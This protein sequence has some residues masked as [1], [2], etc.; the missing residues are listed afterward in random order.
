MPII[1]NIKKIK[2]ELPKN[3]SLVAATK[4]RAIDE[5]KEAI[6]SGIK[7]I[8]ENYVQEAE[9]KFE[10]IGKKVEWHLIGHLQKN[11][12]NRALKIFDMFQTIDSFQLAEAIDK[13]ANKQF[14]ILTEVNIGNEKTKY[15]C[16]PD[17]IFLLIK[18]ISELENIKIKGLMAI[19]PYFKEPEKTRPYFKNM[20]LLFEKIKKETNADMKI[21][22]MGMTNDYKI[23]IEEGSNMLRIGTGIFGK[24]KVKS[25]P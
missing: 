12:I 5:I 9:K 16:K 19:T 2:N 3:V 18:K 21:L 11:K 7:I 6:N 24:R 1:E 14:P 10:A 8:G 25:P 13:R 15:G 4:S 20:K 22:S 23:A 17:E